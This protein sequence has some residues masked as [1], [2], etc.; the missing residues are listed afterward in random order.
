MAFTRP[1]LGRI[2]NGCNG[3]CYYCGKDVDPFE[4]WEPDHLIPRS[5]GGGDELANLVLSCRRCNRS[6]GGRTVD[7]YRDA[8]INRVW[9]SIGRALD[10]SRTLPNHLITPELASLVSHLIAASDEASVSSIYFYGEVYPLSRDEYDPCPLKQLDLSLLDDP[11]IEGK[12]GQFGVDYLKAKR[13]GRF[14]IITEDE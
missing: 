4:H 10:L 3:R 11:E 1:F 12:L 2:Y 14:R 13:D 7:E 9:D 5:Q 6:K 8:L